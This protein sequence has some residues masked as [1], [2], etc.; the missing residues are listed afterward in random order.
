MSKG[1]RS[2]YDYVGMNNTEK[3]VGR[4]LHVQDNCWRI[5]IVVGVVLIVIVINTITNT[6]YLDLSWIK[7]AMNYLR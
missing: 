1:W 3:Y 5:A 4:I 2:D 7:S 6:N